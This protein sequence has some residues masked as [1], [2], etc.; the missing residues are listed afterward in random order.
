VIKASAL[1]VALAIGLLVAGVVGSSLL[2]VYVSIGV[3]AV[4]ALLLAV[5][6]ASHWSEIF[7]RREVRPAS[8]QG[9]WSEPQV[10]VTAPVLASIQA[11]AVA[12][13]RGSGRA[14]REEAGVRPD[15]A[16]PGAAR[17]GGPRPDAVR[18]GSGR[19]PERPAEVV[20]S[21]AEV[22]GRGDEFPAAGRHDDLWERVEEELG[23]AA[24]RDTGALSWPGTVFPPVPPDLPVSAESAARAPEAWAQ[25]EPRA[26]ASAWIWGSGAGWQPPETADPAW[27]PPAAAFAEPQAAPKPAA[28]EPAA[29]APP[30]TEPVAPGPDAAA[31]DAAGSG[32]PGDGADPPVPD[33]TAAEPA[34]GAESAQDTDVAEGTEVAPDD[35]AAEDA[36]AGAVPADDTAP[37]EGVVPDGGASSAAEDHEAAEPAVQSTPAE[38][39]TGDDG[40]PWIIATSR[41]AGQEPAA[42]TPAARSPAAPEATAGKPAAEKPAAGDSAV[43]APAAPAP[44]ADDPGTDD[45]AAKESAAQKSADKEPGPGAP[46][47]AAE[48]PARDAASARPATGRVEVTVV[49]GVARYHRSGCILIRFLGAGD[50]EIMTRQEAEDA[51]FAACRACQPDQLED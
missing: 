10:H 12:A 42:A 9:A 18:P 5:G 34:S 33:E 37:D 49:P 38:P 23:S 48:E 46:E 13:A 25:G 47:P 41:P 19:A 21:P 8:E 1:L 39:A 26:G 32:G 20:P 15:G 45:R 3:C 30:V 50:L 6:V 17:P 31:P 36:D 35:E 4:A 29:V 11:Q 24:K 44:G 14:G 27:P 2:M 7:G 16:R 28:A 51:K 22:A 43:K 40:S